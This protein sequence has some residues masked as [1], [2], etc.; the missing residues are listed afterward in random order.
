[1][2]NNAVRKQK[3]RCVVYTRK[4][5]EEGLERDFNS[6]DAQREA[7][8]AYVAS[9]KEEG[10]VC[11][12]DRYDDGGFSGG[13]T[14]RPAFQRLMADVAEGRIDCILV[15]KVDRLSRSLLDFARIMEAFDKNG[16]SLVSVTQ[17]FNTTTSM[18]R[19]TLNILLSFAQFEREIISERTRDKMGA[20]RR[21]GKWT[22]GPPVL[23][24]DLLRESGGPRLVINKAE[25]EAVRA[26]YKLYLD[27]GSVLAA[28]KAIR[29]RGW[30]TKR[31]Q[32]LKGAWRG[33]VEFDKSVLYKLL[34]NVLYLGKVSYKG[35]VFEG[36]HEAIIDEEMFGRVQ[37][38][39]RHN[40]DSGG[41]YIRNKH[42][43]LLKG[44]VRCK[45]CGCAMSHHFATRGAKRYRYYVCI[46]AQKQGWDV[47]PAPSLPAGQLE[48]FV[49]EQ[50]KGL[51]KDNAL[52]EESVRATQAKLQAEIDELECDRTNVEKRIKELGTEV[53]KLAGKAGYDEDATRRLERLQERMRE[54][55]QEV[56]RANERIT[57]TRR[58]MLEP[59]ELA[60]AVEAFDPLWESLPPTQQA[61]LIHL[62]V[63]RIEYDGE[64]ETIS[65][66]F[67]PTGIRTLTAEYEEATA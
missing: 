24:Y 38:L 1:M 64:K 42:G 21:K 54:E 48:R 14:D 46:R 31:Y 35:D 40:R 50:V 10:W 11:L 30:K 59:D 28:A 29:A 18:G 27:E 4:S 22:G 55:E 62:L 39:L 2:T 53:G 16:V 9:Q 61:R 25:A 44:L 15:Y 49:V 67:H 6:L 34:T 13:N 47:C 60:G 65:L 51:G 56:T 45:H 17:Q 66:A 57:R 52:L 8:E 20:A 33:G 19:L 3:L 26:I 58:R 32:S 43:A 41:K 12:P 5:T 37:G 7:G 23:G 63:D 36:E